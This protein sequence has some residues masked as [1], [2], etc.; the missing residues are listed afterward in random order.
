MLWI[1]MFR[2]EKNWRVAFK[3][4]MRARGRALFAGVLLS[5]KPNHKRKRRKKKRP[6]KN[7]K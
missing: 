5:L 1:I 2:T 4:M 3:I 7:K 6:R